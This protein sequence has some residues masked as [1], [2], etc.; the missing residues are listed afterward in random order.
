[1]IVGYCRTSTVE[2]K[3]GLEAQV[4]ALQHAGCERF[5]AEQISSIAKRPQLEAALAF[6]RDGDTLVV[7]RLDRLARSTQDLLSI[8]ERL[9]QTGLGLRIL[10][11]AGSAIDSTKAVDKL[12]ITVFAAFA[13]FERNL[14]LE[15]QR[16]GIAKAKAEGKYK[17]RAPTARSQAD[18]IVSLAERG[19]TKAAIAEALGISPRSVFRVLAS[20][21]DEPNRPRA[22]LI[23][24]PKNGADA[25][26]SSSSRTMRDKAPSSDQGSSRGPRHRRHRS[27][28]EA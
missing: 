25:G 17:G 12:L 10:D 7:T 18:Q 2:Q 11:F 15:R 8:V 13:E 14:M 24:P 27:R 23:S 3:A 21:G 5:F 28:A 4:T 26:S 16:E 1:V 20:R 22:H 9:D 19:L 6:V